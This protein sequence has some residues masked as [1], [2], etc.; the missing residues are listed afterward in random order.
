V[1]VETLGTLVERRLHA[2]HTIDVVGLL[3]ITE[4]A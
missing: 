4:K 2:A 3:R 1:Q